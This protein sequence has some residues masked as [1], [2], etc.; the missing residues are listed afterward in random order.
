MT[1]IANLLNSQTLL[2]PSLLKGLSAIISS[3]QTLLV[4]TTAPEE[5][6]KQFGVDQEMAKENMAYLKTMAKDTTS[7]LLNVFSLLP[8]EQRG[9]VGDV[10]GLWTGIMAE[11]VSWLS[12][13]RR[14]VA[15]TAD[16]TGH[17]R[18]IHHSDYSSLVQPLK[19][20]PRRAGI[21][22][23]LTYDARP[24]HRLCPSFAYRPGTSAVQ[25]YSYPSD[26]GA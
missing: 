8:R 3:S 2:L 6:R 7:V 12:P 18:Y 25:R 4:S 1:L 10:I 19:P 16:I 20:L 5:L 14:A 11:Q 15:I 9:M 26:V 13:G 22:A 23:Y 17:H 24:P 21:L